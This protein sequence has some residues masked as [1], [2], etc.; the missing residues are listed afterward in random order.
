MNTRPIALK[1]LTILLTLA[2]ASTTATALWTPTA[3][4]EA[5]MSQALAD[6]IH[7]E[8]AAPIDALVTFD[9][10]IGA[11]GVAALEAAGLDVIR[12]FPAFPVAYVQGLGSAL[13]GLLDE[14]GVL[15][16]TDNAALEYHG[17]TATVA[18]RAREAWDD[19]STSTNPVTVGGDVVDGSG[20]GIA[21]IDSGIDAT[22]PDLAGAVAVNQKFVCTTP[23][24]VYVPTGTCYGNAMAG[25]LAS[26]A[27]ITGCTEELWIDADNTDHTSG[28]G[29]HVAG[30]AAGRGTASDGRYM[31]AAPDATLFG[32]GV[33][34]TLLVLYALEAFNWVA[35]NA[36]SQGIHVVSNSW[37]TNAAYAASDPINVAVDALVASGLVVVFAAGNDGGTGSAERVNTY[38]RNPTAGVISVA[39]YDDQDTA[40]RAG[41]LDATSSRC[42]VSGGSV[43]VASRCPDVS[44]PGAFITSTVAKTATVVPATAINYSPYYGT[45]SGTSMAAPHVSG[46]V[47]LLLEAAPGLSPATVEDVLEDNAVQFT[48]PG[49]YP[50]GSDP[51]NPTNG[52]NH[53]AGHGLVDAIASLE[54]SRVLGGSG[55][56]SP[57]AQLRPGPHVYTEGTLDGQL[58]AGA[59]PTLSLQ[60]TEV[61]GRPVGLSERSLLSGN[62]AT[63]GLSAGQSAAFRVAAPGGS[64][65]SL[66]TSVAADGTGAFRMDSPFTFPAPGEYRVEAQIDYGGGLVSVDAF[67]VR[68]VG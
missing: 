56:G 1:P 65:T 3:P 42:M 9:G 49:G 4:S 26:G 35:C 31:G 5:S 54:D 19:K 11:P 36:S 13:L 25:V 61:A 60:W 55:L 33:G 22:H 63:Y 41:V 29:T 68:V 28:H 21:I 16:V 18:T 57:L 24:L 66:T 51:S 59:P 58:A 6:R 10:A 15:H 53:G 48:T 44:A 8:P 32:L 62:T 2:M 67:T 52:I 46:I 30:I 38:A 40:T 23:G 34:E 47:A 27:P 64:V 17:E 43:L 39:N 7:A 50:S 45:A 20:V 12:V 14:P 37:G